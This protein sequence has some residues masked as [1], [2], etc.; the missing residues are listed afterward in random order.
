M[1]RKQEYKFD[2]DLLFRSSL[3]I[4][5]V[6]AAELL[7]YASNDLA[8]NGSRWTRNDFMKLSLAVLDPN[9]YKPAITMLRTGS[10]GQESL[11]QRYDN[12]IDGRL[13]YEGSNCGL[14]RHLRN[15]YIL[16]NCTNLTA[17]EEER[18]AHFLHLI[19]K[20]VI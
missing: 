16:N 11:V 13:I 20:P 7:H 4:R 18:A 6:I 3:E 12:S 1:S 5:L 9:K 17:G 15:W 2:H 19:Y 10:P 14:T 8:V